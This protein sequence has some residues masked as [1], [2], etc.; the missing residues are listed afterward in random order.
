[1]ICRT[2]EEAFQAGWDAPCEHG[3][4][5]PVDCPGC[6]LTPEEIRL[7]VAMHRPYLRLSPPA[8]DQPA[9]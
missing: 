6:R 4:P 1:V 5:N 3:V 9:A 2:P 8:A 7:L